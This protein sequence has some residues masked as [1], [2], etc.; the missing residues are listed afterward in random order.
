MRRVFPLVL[1]PLVAA[2]AAAGPS[3]EHLI[4]LS[5][6]RTVA[7]RWE[8][9]DPATVF[10]AGDEVRFRFRSAV[11]GYLYVL[12]ETSQGESL[13]L[14]PRSDSGTDNRV[15][16]A[17]EYLVPATE[18]FFVIPPQAGY[19]VV[20]WIVS[21]KLLALPTN[22]G[23]RSRKLSHR[24]S[25]LHP[26]CQEGPLRARGACIDNQAGARPLSDPGALSI[27]LGFKP[28]PAPPA[29]ESGESSV[30]IAAPSGGLVVYEFRVAHR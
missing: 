15:E 14:F 23:V 20:Y 2:F 25:T 8:T 16:G 6:E 13:W 22:S 26:R 30:R 10:R 28:A 29:I 3:G 18:G 24:S 19:D 7:G 5:V 27:L 1:Y 17:K 12:N 4:D 9:T 11:P 21:P